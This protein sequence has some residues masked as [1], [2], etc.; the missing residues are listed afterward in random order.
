MDGVEY[1]IDGRKYGMERKKR[2]VMNGSGQNQRVV[3]C[4]MLPL[5]LFIYDLNGF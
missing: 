4:H 2:D 5:G 3:K 1:M